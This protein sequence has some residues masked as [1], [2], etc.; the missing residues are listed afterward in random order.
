MYSK[1]QVMEMVWMHSRFYHACLW[2]CEELY[3]EGKGFAS[4]TVLFNCLEN[5][6][7][8]AINDYISRTV[9]IYR[10]IYL[11]GIITEC[12]HV[13]LNDGPYC[14][15]NVRNLYAHSNVASICVVQQDATSREIYSF[16][17]EDETSLLIYEE[18]SDIVYNLILK[19]LVVN[20]IEEVRDKINILLDDEIQKV[21]LKFKI[22]SS[23][24]ILKI[25]GFP[26]DYF[27]K[28]GDVPEH[29]KIR[30]LDNAPDLGVLGYILSNAKNII[31]DTK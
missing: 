18:L 23:E 30:L 21:S 16:L 1:Q 22:L 29:T 20:F 4:I 9:D 27:S 19:I 13:F 5:I 10:K 15:R 25:K 7:K 31:N 14:L 8:S 2:Q 12:E 6:V 28:C 3:R 26:Q 24:E 17:S 11:A